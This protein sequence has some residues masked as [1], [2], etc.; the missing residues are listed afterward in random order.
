MDGFKYENNFKRPS[1]S[2]ESFSGRGVFCRLSSSEYICHSKL[3]T[4]FRT[5]LFLLGLLMALNVL[6]SSACA[7]VVNHDES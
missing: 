3:Y 1:Q 4:D 5:Y 2:Q 6:I 7:E